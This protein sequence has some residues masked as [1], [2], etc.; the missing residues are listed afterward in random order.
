MKGMVTTTLVIP[1]HTEKIKTLMMFNDELVREVS[2][3][4]HYRLLRKVLPIIEFRM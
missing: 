3:L 1:M 4:Q 2:F